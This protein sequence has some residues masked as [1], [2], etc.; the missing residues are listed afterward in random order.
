MELI[1]LWIDSFKNIKNQGFNLSSKYNVL[2][3]LN[4]KNIEVNKNKNIDDL[5]GNNI[6]IT[7]IIGKNGTGKSNIIKLLYKLL[8]FNYIKKLLLMYE[9]FEENYKLQI[10]SPYYQLESGTKP[11]R[12]K[13]LE[14]DL[15][16]LINE[17]NKYQKVLENFNNDDQLDSSF[18]IIKEENDWYL[19]SFNNLK[20][21]IKYEKEKKEFLNN[22]KS[23]MFSVHFN[24]MLDSW[25]DGKEDYWIDEIY[26]N[27]TNDHVFPFLLE[28]NKRNGKKN[29]VNLK[30]IN[31]TR[32]Q[33]QLKFYS[34]LENNK[35]VTN[36]FSPNNVRISISR[37]KIEN[38][39]Q[40][41]V[42]ILTDDKRKNLISNVKEAIENKNYMLLN[43]TYIIFKLLEEKRYLDDIIVYKEE[44]EKIIV[45]NDT[46][47]AISD[48]FTRTYINPIQQ[49]NNEDFSKIFLAMLLGTNLN[50]NENE[51]DKLIK[52]SYFY[53]KIIENE[54]NFK[55]FENLFNKVDIP[56]CK[57]LFKFL[58]AWIDIEFFENEKSFNTLSSGEKSFFSI[59]IDIL[60]QINTAN[61][62]KKY[63]L[64]NI[65]LDETELGLHP[66]WQCEYVSTIIN[67]IKQIER[68]IKV[69]LIILSHSPF[70][71]SDIPKQNIIFLDKY[72]K[73]DV[74]VELDSN[75]LGKCNNVTSRVKFETFL[76]NIHT[77]LKE[78]FFMENSPFGK[79]AEAEILEIVKL[80]N[81]VK[82]KKNIT[83]VEKDE[84]KVLLKRFYS[85]QKLIG[86][87]YLSKL[88]KNHINEIERIL[89][90]KNLS[91]IEYIIKK[92]GKEEISRFLENKK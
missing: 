42:G 85:I 38:K 64:I 76:S 77:L 60:Y 18:L 84:Y 59:I 37:E 21:N 46:L 5:F 53:H 17:I 48:E 88:V 39:I 70:I 12:K 8:I 3:D 62:I 49:Y 66:D 30:S 92:Y 91:E 7:A 33:N 86:D 41:F 44:L 65:I 43:N 34:E 13:Q 28:P 26:L 6:N 89:F 10:N 81:L 29:M 69:N 9:K 19:L 74:K 87:T 80:Y 47:E 56:K 16:R 25:F 20:L 32:E 2:F 54:S 22:M 57:F 11:L 78:N 58:P 51:L 23:E 61:E 67:A 52:S 4:D 90:D 75:L 50:I 82:N 35:I 24:Y 63:K 27:S 45:E 15:N 40:K 83:S 79:Y 72:T 73:S 55:I 31:Y 71:I 14:K 36:I 1:Y 68:D